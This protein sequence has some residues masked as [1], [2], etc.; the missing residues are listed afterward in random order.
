MIVNIFSDLLHL[1]RS[2]NV[3]IKVKV[4]KKR[5]L[6]LLD[7]V[8]VNKKCLYVLLYNFI[9]NSLKMVEEKGEVSLIID[10]KKS[11]N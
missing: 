5:H 8:Q 1:I 6:G 3:T 4:N 9:F 10:I 11:L 2:K 7:N